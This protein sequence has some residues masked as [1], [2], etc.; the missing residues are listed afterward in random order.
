MTCTPVF[1]ET[2][3]DREAAAAD[4]RLADA[5][6]AADE[7]RMPVAPS[8]A[9][10]TSGDRSGNQLRP[11][12]FAD[13][14]GQ[15]EASRLMKRVIEATVD[16]NRPL[17]HVLMVGASG[18]GK[19]TFATVIAE[20]LGV[21]CFQLEAPV[22]A[23]MLLELREV[24]QYGD[25]VLIDE[26][27]MQASQDRRGAQASMSPEAFY[28]VL[29]DRTIVSRGEVLPFPEVTFIG[30]T[31]DEGLLP[32]PFLNRFPLRPHLDRYTDEEM[33]SIA[34]M[35]AEKLDIPITDEAAEMFGAA[36]R[37]TP[38]VLNSYMRNA[39]LLTTGVIDAEIAREVIVDLNRTTLD[40]LTADM[41]GMLT[42][43][44]TRCRRENKDGEVVYQGSVSTVSTALGK[45]RDTKAVPLRIEPELIRRGF[46]QVG[47]AGRVLTEAGITRAQ[48]ILS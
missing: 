24:V 43:L 46:L 47:H 17:D 25:V 32:E 44:Y 35:N 31:T 12:T 36:S 10:V 22:S 9:P 45:G 21:D 4:T 15:E 18:T 38:R 16:R 29:E 1:M 33:T 34:R 41:A 39:V 3:T 42:F 13:V 26:I 14:I 40:G 5:L 37:A 7:Y 6:H 11:T 2:D 19:T 28:N 30:A 48:E 23:E 20:E 27:H 8:I